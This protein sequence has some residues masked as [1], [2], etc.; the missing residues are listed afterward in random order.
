MIAAALEI[1]RRIVVGEH[2]GVVDDFAAVP[3]GGNLHEELPRAP[4]DQ[5]GRRRIEHAGNHSALVRL[6]EAAKQADIG[7]V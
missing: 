2:G 6:P 7:V 1:R 3:L 4:V 5:V